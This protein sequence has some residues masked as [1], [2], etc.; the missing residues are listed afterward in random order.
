MPR[1]KRTPSGRRTRASL[2][3]SLI[4]HNRLTNNALDGINL[5]AGN[6]GNE[7]EHNRTDDNGSD[8]IHPLA[9]SRRRTSAA[10]GD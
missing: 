1:E 5:Q 10:S 9:D 2:I 6:T 8:G 3:G 7:V 4:S